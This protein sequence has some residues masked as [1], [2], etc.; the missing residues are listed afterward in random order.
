MTF[1]PSLHLRKH[2]INKKLRE[3][4]EIRPLSKITNELKNNKT[5][6]I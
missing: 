5:K 3:K 4:R 1:G 2:K 6:F